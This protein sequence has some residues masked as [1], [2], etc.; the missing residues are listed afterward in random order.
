MYFLILLLPL[1]SAIFAG[2]FGRKLGENGAGIFTTSTIL[3]SSLLAWFIWFEVGLCGAVTYIDLGTWMEAGLF[4]I[5]YGLLFDSISSTMLVLV[6]TVSGLVH[7]YS[8]EYMRGDPHKPRFMSYLSLFTFFM[9]VLVTSDNYVQL[10]IGWE[11]VGLCSYLLINFWYTRIQ[12][13]KSAIKAMIVNRVGDIGLALGMLVAFKEFKALDFATIFSMTPLAANSSI[14]FFGQELNTLTVIGILIL[15][16]A[17]GKSAQLG[18]HT[19]LPDAMEGPTPVSALIHAATMV[20]SCH[21]LL[22]DNTE[23]FRYMLETPEINKFT[24][25]GVHL[26]HETSKNI[27]FFNGGRLPTLNKVNQQETNAFIMKQVGSSE[28]V[29]EKTLNFINYDKVKPAQVGKID[30][31]FLTWFIGLVEGSGS[32]I[33]SNEKVYINI[34]LRFK[35]IKL[36]HEIRTRLGFGK[37][38]EKDGHGDQGE[39]GA[40]YYVSGKDNFI[41]LAHLFNGNLVTIYKREQFKLWLDV[42]NKQYGENIEHI[43]SERP[44]SIPSLN[45]AWLSGYIETKGCFITKVKK[46]EASPGAVCQ[47]DKSLDFELSVSQKEDLDVLSYIITGTAAAKTKVQHDISLDGSGVSFRLSNKNSLKKLITYIDRHP[48]KTLKRIDYLKWTKRYHLSQERVHLT[49][50]G[51][52]Q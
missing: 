37:I 30:P 11:G 14:I 48:L 1:L 18:L 33:R 41:R 26:P 27:L 34:P 21:L 24:S 38:L 32:F 6:T 12:A 52:K 49:A 22:W 46:C 47:H 20:K 15:I 51:A 43:N 10:F 9:I 31:Q 17:V 13:N 23:K 29:C 44:R 39:E 5:K 3:I 40:A 35:D 7:W 50:V 19:W 36:L 16:G 25:T 42:L 2:L 4:Q 45:D 28:T 8:T